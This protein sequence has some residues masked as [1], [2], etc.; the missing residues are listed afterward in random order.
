MKKYKFALIGCGRISYKHINAINAI[1]N[2]ELI[3][4]SISELLLFIP[5]AFSSILLPKFARYEKSFADAAAATAI[6]HILALALFLSVIIGALG[7]LI[8]H[9]L[10]GAQFST[11]FIPLLILLFGILTMSIVGVIFKFLCWKRSP[12]DPILHSVRRLYLKYRS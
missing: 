5:R 8:I 9:F 6:R 1:E 7:R 3:A 4:V 11:A 12:G 2:A 10:Y